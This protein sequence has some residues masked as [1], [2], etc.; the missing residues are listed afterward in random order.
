MI[1]TIARKNPHLDKI[2]KTYTQFCGYFREEGW[3][4]FLLSTSLFS[5]KEHIYIFAIK[6]K[7]NTNQAN[8]NI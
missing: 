3:G 6:K 1:P 4:D 5:V 7:K 2:R 8:K